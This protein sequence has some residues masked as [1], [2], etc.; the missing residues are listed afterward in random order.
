MIW[1]Q[2]VIS[3]QN[4]RHAQQDRECAEKIAVEKA[5]KERVTAMLAAKTAELE[6]EKEARK[7]DLTRKEAELEAAHT[8]RHGIVRHLQGSC[9]IL[10]GITMQSGPQ[11]SKLMED[12]TVEVS[13]LVEF[14]RPAPRYSNTDRDQF[15]K[16]I[17]PGLATALGKAHEFDMEI[18]NLIGPKPEKR[19]S[20]KGNSGGSSLDVV[21]PALVPYKPRNETPRDA[22]DEDVAARAITTINRVPLPPPPRLLAIRD[23]DQARSGLDAG[24]DDLLMAWKKT[25]GGNSG[26]GNEVQEDEE[27]E[28]SV[29]PVSAANQTGSRGSKRGAGSGGNGR[30]KVKKGRV[31]EEEDC[32]SEHERFKYGMS[33]GELQR[34]VNR[35]ERRRRM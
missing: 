34:M 27:N 4:A 7:A 25:D 22:N 21:N 9:R 2:C 19:G 26:D 29:E 31:G 23:A 15:R 16:T 3:M 18:K 17:Y 24:M 11:S 20:K 6:A 8:A 33:K 28:D 30:G 14:H 5:E 1:W 12:L 13:R 35:E 10:A 32:A